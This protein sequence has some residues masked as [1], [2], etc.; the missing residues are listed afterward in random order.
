MIKDE[1]EL[2]Q[3]IQKTLGKTSSNVL[4]G[5]GD[6]AAVT[7]PPKGKMV[8]TVDTLV[9]GVHFDLAYTTARELGHKALAVSLSDLAA[10]GAKPLYAL[11]SLGLTQNV[12]EYFVTE[13]YRGMKE[14]ARKFKVD[15]I[16]GNLVQSPTGMLIDVTAIGEAPKTFV[17]RS[18]AKIG[19]LVAVTGSLG[20]SAA[21]LNCLR[22]LGRVR[23]QGQE[24]IIDAHLMPQPRV[25]EALSMQ[26]TGALTAMIDIS[27]GLARE[28]HHLANRSAVGFEIDVSALSISEQTR[29]GASLTNSD[30]L[31]WALYGG[32]D[33]E[34]LFTFKKEKLKAIKAAFKG[35]LTVIG[36][37]VAKKNGVQLITGDGKSELQPK[38]WN[39]FVRRLPAQA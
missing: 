7:K 29:H 32:E 15:I 26:K 6:D 13:F 2:I 12:N 4:L 18:G 1:F 19:N 9:E 28:V 14:L 17:T 38:G 11:V 36:R 35:K 22:R 16:G 10:M 5:I 20:E 39:H 21:G 24:K 23:M 34:L 37:V 25:H 30:P 8:T 27:D 3:L 33:Y 31:A